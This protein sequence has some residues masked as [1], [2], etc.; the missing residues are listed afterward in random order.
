MD[1]REIEESFASFVQNHGIDLQAAPPSAG[2]DA[3]IRFYADQRADECD[4]SSEGDMLLFQWGT[5]DWGDGV[6]FELDLTRQ[7]IFPDEEYDDAI[8][9]L[10]LTYRFNPTD[11]LW[12]IG[13]GNKWC[14]SPNDL[15]SFVD[16]LR[17]TQAY[18]AVKASRADEVE[19]LFE[20]AG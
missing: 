8:W 16:Y 12:D 7:V 19:V 2:I 13:A 9:Q 11:E 17:D 18:S 6:R 20:C 15:D 3:M 1:P 14:A 10:H 5:Y 4:L